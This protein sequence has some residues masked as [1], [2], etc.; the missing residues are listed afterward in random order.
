MKKTLIIFAISLGIS[1]LAFSQKT[2][3]NPLNNPA[4]KSLI[5]S[6]TSNM[7]WSMVSGSNK[8]E[9]GNIQT[10]IQKDDEKINIITTI[11]MKQSPVKWVDSTVVESKN[12][13]PIY[14]SSF[15]HQRDMVL[16]FGKKIT[17]YYLNKKTGVKTQISENTNDSYFDSNFYP[18]LIRLLPLENGYSKTISIFDY[19]PTAKIG[20]IT[21]TIKNTETATIDFNGTK[22][23]VW[24][25]EATDDI[26]NNSAVSTYYI[27]TTT[28]QIIKQKVDLGGRKMIMELTQ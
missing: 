7:T 22:K 24:K 27:D 26:S 1:S 28:R 9:I 25:V 6:E 19:N 2:F 15:N 18:Q 23:Q 10:Q 14:H 8:M 5:Q 11:N 13:K 20:V 17:G 21:A 3:L 4:D 16:K 12:F